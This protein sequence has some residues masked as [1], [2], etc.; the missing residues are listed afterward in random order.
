LI[1][2]ALVAIAV[3][4]AASLLVSGTRTRARAEVNDRHEALIDEDV[5]QIQELARSYT[6]CSG[7]ATFD[8]STCNLVG[9][10]SEDYYFPNPIAADGTG[11]TR[12]VDLVRACTPT[13]GSPAR[14]DLINSL[15][16]QLPAAQLTGINGEL[17][18]AA[19]VPDGPALAQRVLITY[20]NQANTVSRRVILTPT[21][22]SWC[23]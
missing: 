9:P 13:S 15:I 22:A 1:G 4:G 23:P 18:R 3:A 10:G 19:A 5:S 11:P 6:W 16:A 20:T 7:A 2:S 12:I 17:V 21:V 14:T 8:G